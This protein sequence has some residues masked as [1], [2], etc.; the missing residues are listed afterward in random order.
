MKLFLYI[1]TFT[2]QHISDRVHN[3]FSY[4]N[5]FDDLPKVMD[6]LNFD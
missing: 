6:M 3:A 5:M 1:I 2:L 4:Y